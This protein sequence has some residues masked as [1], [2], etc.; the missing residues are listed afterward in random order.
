MPIRY[1]RTLFPLLILLLFHNTLPAQSGAIWT[2]DYVKA[3]EGQYADM[4]TYYR[5]N[6][7]R[8]RQIA[9]EKAY[10]TDFRLLLSPGDT[11]W[12]V[13]LMTRYADRAQR[14]QA[15]AHF[16]EI[17]SSDLPAPAPVN[18]KSGRELRTIVKSQ[19]LEE[20]SL[21][22]AGPARRILEA[23]A[24]IRRNIASFSEN[25]V[26]GQWDAVADAYTDDA[27][28]FPPQFDILQGTDAIR[29]YWTPPAERKNRISY[30]RITPLEISISDG[31]AF[32]WG[33]YEGKTRNEAGEETYWRGKYLIIWKET[34]PGVWK[35]YADC[36][37]R[38]P[39]P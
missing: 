11:S 7:V 3:K 36:W 30:H 17:F 20:D 31:Q 8:A 38:S 15:E 12:D 26:N 13:L 2:V 18:G 34:E 19:E 6:W 24:T 25:L 10:I 32:D 1:T 37:N 21:V 22:A 39:A 29:D 5:A 27:K 33:Y 14:D 28:L 9:Q 35:I 4:L 23:E 16:Q